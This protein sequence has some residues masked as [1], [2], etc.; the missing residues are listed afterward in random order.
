M[1]RLFVRDKQFY[2]VLA[3]LTFTLALQNLITFGV[4]LADNVMVGGYSQAALNGVAIVNQIQFLLQMVCTGIVNGITVLA[5]QYWGQRNVP[6]IRRIFTVGFWIGIA[7]AAALTLVG[8]FAPKWLLSLLTDEPA[9]I[10]EGAKY[11]RIV[12]FTYGLF[13]VSTLLL[14]M[15]RSVE[16]VKIGFIVSAMSLVVNICLNYCLI[17]G[18]L[19]FP[20]LGVRG[21]AIATLASRALEFLVVVLYTLFSDRKIRYRLSDLLH[22]DNTYAKD[23]FRSGLPLVLSNTSW[24]IAM[25]IQ[26]AIIGRLGEAAISANSIATTIFQVVSVLVYALASASGVVIGKTVGEGRI[27]TVKQYAVTL[28]ILYLIVGLITSLALFSVRNW[29]VSLYSVTEESA[30]L[31]RSFIL[32]L[33]VTVIGTAY[34]MSALS[35]IVSAGGQTRFVLFNDLI[36][37]WGIVLPVSLLSAFVFKWSSLF[38]FIC[39]KSDQ[40]LKCAVAVVKVNRFRWIR[41]LTRPREQTEE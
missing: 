13:T 35:G 32:V 27:E 23:F 36:F 15:L 38:T 17:Q 39:L 33:C 40:V 6:P 22:W 41:V 31:A 10:T 18:N 3:T 9:A 7:F 8:F 14:G 28:Q 25:T 5:A 11:L 20:E 34:Q 12:C 19:G 24:G 26:T 1:K 37:M 4:N 29:I 16:T 30:E 21:A 2:S